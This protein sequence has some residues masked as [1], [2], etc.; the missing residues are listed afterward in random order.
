MAGTTNQFGPATPVPWHGDPTSLSLPLSHIM[1]SDQGAS[2]EFAP[3][4]L[5]DC[6]HAVVSDAS[7]LK[8]LCSHGI[9]S[10]S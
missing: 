4:L 8:C 3:N 6:H 5:V 9:S 10:F 7:Y 2:I 1:V